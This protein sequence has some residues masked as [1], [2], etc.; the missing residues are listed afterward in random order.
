MVTVVGMADVVGVCDECG[1][2]FAGVVG[3]KFCCVRCRETARKRRYRARVA[4]GEVR[5]RRQVVEDIA[6]QLK[7]RGAE[8]SAREE[9]ERLRYVL[10]DM[11]EQQR[12]VALE[13][14]QLRRQV[15]ELTVEVGERVRDLASIS[16]GVVV[17]LEQREVLGVLPRRLREELS[18]WVPEEYNPWV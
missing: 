11:G 5:S 1:G 8:S 10:A 2:G 9:A 3:Q 15:E 4:S 17:V 7:A 16:T 12:R 18:K 6:V 14:A 13:N